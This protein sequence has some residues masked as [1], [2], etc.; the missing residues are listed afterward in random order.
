MEE[1]SIDLLLD[2]V[3]RYQKEGLDSIKKAYLL[4]EKLHDGQKRQSGEPYI[5]HPLSVA[6]ILS[7]MHADT[8][9]IC[10]A[11]LHDTIEDSSI[12]KEE[13]ALLF[14]P[15]VA[16]LVDG[17][18]KIS[19]LNFSSKEEQN[20][21][22]TRKIILSLTEDVRIIIIKLA[23]RLHNMRTLQ[24]KSR[25]KQQENALETLE[26]FA[27][28]AY[29]LGAY[30]I[31]NELEDLSLR[32]LEPKLYDNYQ[33]KRQKLEKDA[34]NI[35]L[36]TKDH[37]QEKLEEHKINN[38]IQIRIKNI[39]GLY[40]KLDAGYSLNTIHDL[41][42]LKVITEKVEDCYLSLGLIHSIYPPINERFKDYICNPKTNYYQSLHTTIYGE[43]NRLVQIQIRTQDMDKIAN[44]GIMTYFDLYQGQTREIMQEKLKRYQ[45]YHSLLEIDEVLGDNQ[46]FVKQVK[47]ELFTEKVHTFT[48]DGDIIELPKGSSII[49]FA[50]SLSEDI[51]NTMIGACVNGSMVP[52]EEY[53][54][55]TKD[56]V[57]IITDELAYGPKEKWYHLAKT[58]RAKKLIKSFQEKEHLNR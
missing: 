52:I 24:Y 6:F 30:T 10:A 41:F 4:A 55:K 44:Y 36:T 37:I 31:K 14:N 39:F 21:A 1:L 11:L 57:H 22:N 27:P 32:Y 16:K 53:T 20:L 58:T 54:L 28:L 48:P 7:Q 43:N 19:K 40:K 9:T 46:D 56:R 8:D 50:Y 25:F 5:I 38:H 18:T 15:Q 3:A 2:A 23:D 42:A 34:K 47:R 35:L 12:T 29:Y 49:D 51:G 45:F 33:K 17:V 13:I 26:L